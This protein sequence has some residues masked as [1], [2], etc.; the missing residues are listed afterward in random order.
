MNTKMLLFIIVLVL[1][2]PSCH[3]PANVPTSSP[4]P[5]TVTPDALI[6][7]QVTPSPVPFTATPNVLI[8]QQVTLVSQ[9]YVESHQ[10][11]LFTVTSQTPQLTGSDDPRV[12]TFNQRLDAIIKKELKSFSDEFLLYSA[13]PLPKGSSLEGTYTLTAQYNNIWSFQL[14]F[15][16]Y[17]D[18]ASQPGLYNIP[19]N[20]DLEQGK[21]LVL[22][23]LF[24]PNSNYLEVISDYCVAEL[25]KRGLNYGSIY[26]ATYPIPYNYSDNWNIT[27]EGL[28]I[29]FNQTEVAPREA[30]PQTVIVPH[31]ELKTV[32]TPM[33][34]L[35]SLI[36]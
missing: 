36:Q 30:G 25:V 29:T 34:P 19:I 17:Y 1:I 27:P 33:G 3:P 7:K 28:M 4:I 26:G 11:P 32:I 31:S 13:K 14:H 20:Y 22:D 23:D 21:E 2:L 24:M 8:S 9:S 18:N 16:F 6:G 5:L 35:G 12:Q 10:D 15:L